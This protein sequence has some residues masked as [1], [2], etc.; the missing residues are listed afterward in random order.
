MMY[1]TTRIHLD[2]ELFKINSV[3]NGRSVRAVS[4]TPPPPFC[5]NHD[6]G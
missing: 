1:V 5:K 6:H 3:A 4:P 2:Y